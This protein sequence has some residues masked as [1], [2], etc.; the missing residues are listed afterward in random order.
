MVERIP[1]PAIITA[2]ISV[3]LVFTYLAYTWPGY[4]TNETY[5]GGLLFLEVLIAATWM[6]RKLYFPLVM[7]TFLLAGVDLP[8]GSVWTAAR[9]VTLGV[10]AMIGTFIMLKER[11]YRFGFFHLLAFFVIL[12]ASVSAAGSRYSSMSFYKVFSLLSLF[13]Y[14][15]TGARLAVIGQEN[16]FF[17]WL[18]TACEVFVGA[19]AGLYL[20]GIQAMGNP[21]SLGAVMGVI[22]APILL[23]GALASQEQFERRRRAVMFIICAGLIF[24]SH[25][26]ASMVATFLSCSI[27]CLA[28]RRHKLVVQG[29]AVVIIV[30]TASAILRPKAYSDTLSTLTNS[31][32]FKR[33]N[34]TTGIL[35]SRLSP[36]QRATDSIQSHVWFGTGFGT[37]DNGFDATDHLG[38]FSSTAASSTEFGSSYL[39]ITTWVGVLGVVPFFLLLLI[40]L[41]KVV[42]T[43]RWVFRTG[44]AAH[45][46]IPLAMVM[47][48][49]MIHAGFEDWLF[50]SGY[51]VTVFFWSMAFV[52]VDE[53]PA[54]APVARRAIQPAPVM[55]PYLGIE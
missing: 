43:M 31:V 23:W 13:L 49:G 48:A 35:D 15:G 22:M 36:W 27:L 30:T 2:L 41:K 44:T 26:R 24:Y 42:Q 1:K 55:Q 34:E 3:P 25:A 32:I 47:L 53:A 14:A 12:S 29:I 40:L 18:L 17:S 11:R 10:G 4:F 8:V 45:P 52:F 33:K 46:A 54:P 19:M 16:R 38:K 6:Y 51:Y 50:A 5:L 28:F 20:V 37:S 21:N 9:W 7:I 39:A